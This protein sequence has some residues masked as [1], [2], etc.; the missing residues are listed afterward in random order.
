MKN[1]IFLIL[2]SLSSL[3]AGDMVEATSDCKAFNNKKHTKNM[4]NLTIQ[5]GKSYNI[6]SKSANQ[7]YIRTEHKSIPNRWVERSCFNSTKEGASSS[8]QLL[9]ALSW[10]NAFCETHKGKRECRDSTISRY[11]DKRFGLHGLWPQPRSNIYCKVS[12]NDKKLD[13]RGKWQQLPKL[14][15]NVDTI[16]RLR[17]VMA[18]YDSYL[19]R[20]EWIK[21]GT[22]SNLSPNE[23]YKRAI[24]LTKEFNDSKIGRFFTHNIGKGI[25]L[26]QVIFKMNESFGAGSGR[27]V[28]LRCRG[29]LITEVWLHLG[30]SGDNLSQLLKGGKNVSSR[31]YKGKIDRVGF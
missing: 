21:H 5:K 24:S 22:C 3:W 20:H 7:Y 28:E 6:I 1:I 13:K 19:H 25:T 15:L 17:E 31:C 29:G 18:G 9:L 26:Q 11:T 16:Q 12:S 30:S 8:S 14:N 2:I 4:D 23:Y 27:K 10:Q